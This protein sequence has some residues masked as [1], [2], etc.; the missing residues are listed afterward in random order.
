MKVG[1]LVELSSYAKKL[2]RNA[3]L[4]NKVGIVTE[5][6]NP[7]SIHEIYDIYWI[8]GELQPIYDRVELK[9]FRR[10]G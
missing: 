2:K 7:S 9:H 3:S 1:D 10:K 4:V 8:G 5:I 6:L